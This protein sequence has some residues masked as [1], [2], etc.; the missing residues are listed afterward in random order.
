MRKWISAFTL[1]ELLVVIAI[2]AIL[3][4]LLLP[5]LARAREESRRKA[6]ASNLAQ[7]GKACIA[8]Q[9]PNGEFWPAHWSG[10]Q[11]TD[12]NPWR[13]AVNNSQSDYFGSSN[14]SDPAGGAGC[15]P[16]RAIGLLYPGYIDTY[17]VYRCPSTE[18]SP[19]LN[20][21]YIE[22]ARHLAWGDFDPAATDP[23]TDMNMWATSDISS[24]IYDDF[25]HFRAI[26]PGAAVMSDQ[27]GEAYRLPDGSWAASYT[28]REKN[29]IDGQ[30]VLFMGGHVKYVTETNYFDEEPVDNCYTPDARHA[31][32]NHAYYNGGQQGADT[33][34][35]LWSGDTGIIWCSFGCDVSPSWLA[36]YQ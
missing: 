9:E 18:Q 29:H 11:V 36:R 8:Y 27:S 34:A 30:N 26:G 35:Y 6:C 2:I 16:L 3:A 28:Q 31:H 5:A 23:H 1:I 20:E 4:A 32:T 14:N 19:V 7:L 33:D 12:G 24:Y 13:V 22:G 17:D 25:T 15:N 21:R 10:H